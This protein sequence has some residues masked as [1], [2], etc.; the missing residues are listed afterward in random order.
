[1][2]LLVM[3]MSGWIRSNLPINV[4]YLAQIIVYATANSDWVYLESWWTG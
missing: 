2:M 1:M 4:R 3:D